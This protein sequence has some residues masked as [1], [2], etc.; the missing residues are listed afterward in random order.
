MA[1]KKLTGTEFE[2]EVENGTGRVVVDF[3]A[4]WCG[5]CHQ[6]APELEAL[7]SKWD[8]SVR[9]V[10][11]DIDE[12]PRVAEKYEIYSI[13]TIVLFV[14]GKVVGTTMGAR[15]GH[16]IEHDLGLASGHAA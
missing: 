9:F 4:E 1:L 5:P 13:P 16:E 10:K 14:D 8:G 11:L 3:F 7:A 15:P 2:R 6:I 12:N